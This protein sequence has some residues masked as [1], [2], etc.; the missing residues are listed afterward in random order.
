MTTDIRSRYIRFCFMDSFALSS[1]GWLNAVFILANH[2][3]SVHE[4]KFLFL[5][6]NVECYLLAIKLI[7]QGSWHLTVLHH[8][9]LETHVMCLWHINIFY[10]LNLKVLLVIWS[11]FKNCSSSSTLMKAVINDL[12][13]LA[14]FHICI[15]HEACLKALEARTPL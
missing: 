13:I 11:L 15:Y 12:T 14:D 3:N 4:Q 1:A 7:L 5:S 2:T 10:S 9:I 8:S 6:S